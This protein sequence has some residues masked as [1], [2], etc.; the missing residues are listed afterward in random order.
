MNEQIKKEEEL[1]TSMPVDEYEDSYQISNLGNIRNITTH[2]D[3]TVDIGLNKATGTAKGYR[4]IKLKA[5]GK[6]SVRSLANVVAKAWVPGWIPES[7]VSYLDGDRM[8]CMASNLFYSNQ[9][10]Q[11]LP[12]DDANRG[13]YWVLNPHGETIKL[14][15]YDVLPFCEYMDIDPT[16][17]ESILTGEADSFSNYRRVMLSQEGLDQLRWLSRF[18][19]YPN[20]ELIEHRR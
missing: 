18:E 15:R 6:K 3:R 13:P 11:E 8:N 10:N 20:H 4:V 5:N 7:T 14:R 17:F 12:A 19:F 1:W 16:G 2:Q 9:E